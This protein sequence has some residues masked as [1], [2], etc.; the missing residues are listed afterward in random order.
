MQN[1][2]TFQSKCLTEEGTAVGSRQITAFQ[3]KSITG[4]NLIVASG[5]LATEHLFVGY[6]ILIA[7]FTLF[8]S[9]VPSKILA[10]ESRIKMYIVG[11]TVSLINYLIITN[12][13]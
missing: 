12:I 4:L 8:I 2:E 7:I 5:I 3:L 9:F 11:I 13:F 6:L 10:F 1:I